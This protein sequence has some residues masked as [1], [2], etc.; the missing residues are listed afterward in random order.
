MRKLFV[1]AV[2]VACCLSSRALAINLIYEPFDYTPTGFDLLGKTN[3]SAGTA[4]SGNSWLRASPVATPPTSIDIASGSLLG[5]SELKGSIGNGVTINGL[6]G[7]TTQRPADR[8]SFVTASGPQTTAITS[9]TIYYSFLLRV[10]ALTGANNTDGDNFISLNNTLNAA[11]T[12]DPTVRPGQF[13]ARI[14]PTDGTKFNLGM[15]TNRLPTA[16]D[17]GWASTQL[18]VGQTHFIVGRY[19]VGTTNSTKMWINPDPLTFGL[20]T[21]PVLFSAQDTTSAGTG[22]SIGSLLLHQKTAPF[23]TLD[24]IRM[25]TTWGEVTPLG[26]AT[27]YWDIDG[28]TA[29]AGGVTPSGTWDASTTNWN[30]P[31]GD[32]TAQSW[33][34]GAAAVFSAGNDATGT[35][36]VTVSGTQSANQVTFEDGNVTLTGGT[37]NLTG[38]LHTITTGASNTAAIESVLGG[39]VGFVKDGAGTLVLTNTATYSGT[40]S[41]NVGTVQLGNGGTTGSLP[42]GSAITVSG[43][44]TSNRSNAVTQGTDFSGA[45]ITGTGGL[46]QAGGGTLTLT[47]ANT[48]SGTTRPTI[49]TIHLSNSLALQNSALDMVSS[50]TGA[51]VFDSS[52]SAV[53]LGGV[54]GSRDLSLLNAS[55]GALAATVGGGNA[56]VGPYSGALSGTGSSLI[57]VGTGTQTLSGVNTYSGGTTING[58]TLQLAKTNSMPASGAVTV[59]NGGTLGVNAGGSG[60]WTDSAV[61]TDP[62]SIAGLIAGTGGQ[63]AANQV[64]WNSGSTL[65]V[66]TTNAPGAPS[67]PALTYNGAIGAFSTTGGGTTNAVGFGKRGVGT[68]TLNAAAHTFSGALS[69]SGGTADAT[70]SILVLNGTVLNAGST[71]TI[72]TV[73]LGTF[74]DLSLGASDLLPAGSLITT[75]SQGRLQLNGFN[76]TVRSL[77][78]TNGIVQVGTGTLTINDQAGDD[79]TFGSAGG[80]FLSASDGGK[81]HKV[82]AGT[83]TLA[84]DATN[85]FDGEFIMENGRLNLNR[86]QVFSTVN[87]TGRLTVKAGQLGRSNTTANITY[88]VSAVDLHVFRY[89]LSDGPTFTSQ[90]NVDTTTTLKENNVEFNITASGTQTVSSGKFIFLGDIRNHNPVTEPSASDRGITKTGN[91]VLQIGSTSSTTSTGVTTYKGPTTIQDGVVVLGLPTSTLGDYTQATIGTL[92]LKGGVLGTTVPNNT[93]TVKNPVVVDSAAGTATLAQFG[94]GASAST[95]MEFDNNSIVGTSGSLTITN[96]NNANNS[97]TIFRPRFTGSGFNFGLPIVIS[98]SVLVGTGQKSNELQGGNS[99]GTQT[100]S[101]PIS[102]GGSFRRVNAGGET[103]LSGANTYSGGTTVEAGTLT[104]NSASALGTGNVSVIGGVLSLLN[105]NSIAN[106]AT[107]SIAT[108][109]MVNLGAGVNE[110]LVGLVLDTVAQGNGTYGSTASTAAIQNDTY[111]SGTGIITVGPAGLPGDFNSDGKVDAGDYVT[112]KKNQNTNNALANDNGLGT[113]VGTAHYN[114]W[115]ANFGNPPGSGSGGNLSGTGSVPEP[116]SLVLL[117][118]AIFA[119]FTCGSRKRA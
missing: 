105:S 57:K 43:R 68:L 22:N 21:E 19:N 102:G 118:G 86:A 17:A 107:L 60:E 4:A 84:G 103:V 85:A 58:G 35:Y 41:I 66:D 61:V 1:V 82:G 38:S 87:D 47:A 14:D 27:L 99:S 90:F 36:T 89:D 115:R 69:V 13:R 3:T 8:L 32:G 42:T 25:A 52:L 18:D 79:Y 101:G 92:N 54:T 65:A 94:T 98:N 81:V 50:D 48:F 11:T 44:L 34:S 5:P 49:G 33:N 59:N 95:V 40:T 75:Q 51:V 100:F 6:D 74:S 7:Y 112:W 111:F 88:S 108:P 72:P 56:A 31:N 24:E 67:A 20:G 46:T 77:S 71:M 117:I 116:A 114:L 37:L 10:D 16:S 76:Q 73:S 45:P 23:L 15:F 109:G 63:G 104:A 12:N 83:F 2:V 80:A 93:V 96:L 62:A 106:A 9:G 64:T 119:L 30:N 113:P 28:A 78:G 70:R 55:S 26:A 29:G 91:G 110:M 53:S 97:A 39:S